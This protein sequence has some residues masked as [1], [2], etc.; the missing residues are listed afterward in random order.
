MDGTNANEQY[1]AHSKIRRVGAYGL[2]WNDELITSGPTKLSNGR[3]R[4]LGIQDG[5]EA[6]LLCL[7]ALDQH[8]EQQ[9]GHADQQGVNPEF[10]ALPAPSFSLHEARVRH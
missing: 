8:P 9:K 6:S 1:P 2:V 7:A 10:E 5:S 4:E 3:E